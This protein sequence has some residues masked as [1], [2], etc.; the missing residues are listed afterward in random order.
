MCHISADLCHYQ[1]LMF[2]IW[3][4]STFISNFKFLENNFDKDRMQQISDFHA[5]KYNFLVVVHIDTNLTFV[6]RPHSDNQCL[7]G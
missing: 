2:Y 1:P 7:Y 3:H 4:S 6:L 5:H